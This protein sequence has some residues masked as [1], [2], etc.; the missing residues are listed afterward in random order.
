MENNELVIVK[1]ALNNMLMSMVKAQDAPCSA[2]MHLVESIVDIAALLKID[3]FED[4]EV[5]EHF[6]YCT[7]IMNSLRNNDKT[8]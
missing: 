1:R 6:S 3:D 8:E 5:N 7:Q 4:V 2:E